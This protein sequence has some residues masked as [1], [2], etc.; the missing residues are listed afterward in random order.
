[1]SAGAAASTGVDE[2][3]GQ[4]RSP[5]AHLLHALNQPLTGL[6]CALELATLATRTPEQYRQTLHEGL[7]LTE[8]MRV[9]VEAL[10]EVADMAQDK[11]EEREALALDQLLVDAVEKLKPFAVE[12]GIG[13][14]LS[15]GNRPLPTCGI[16]R[17]LGPA[18][19]RLLDATLAR[20][21]NTTTVEI[22]GRIDGGAVLMSMSWSQDET[23]CEEWVWR[24]REL[25][26]LIAR[27]LWEEMGMQWA[28]TRTAM[29]Q[30]IEIRLPLAV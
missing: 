16:R 27:A 6:Q 18:L 20:A 14:K 5:L 7:E 3:S 8:R 12:R 17:R 1:M 11:P 28:S 30:Q 10:R 21:A 23:G 26:L 2:L 19:V 4:K 13:M 29:S 9:L 25:A 24:H 22:K 15:L